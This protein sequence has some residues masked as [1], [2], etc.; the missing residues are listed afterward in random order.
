MSRDHNLLSRLEGAPPGE[1]RRL[2]TRFVLDLVVSFL[3]FDDDEELHASENFLDLGFNSLRA[4]DFKILLEERLDL[5]LSSTVL[6]DC[7]TPEALVEYLLAVR[8]GSAVNPA[9]A[10]YLPAA[11]HEEL[12]ADLEAL[13]PAELARLLRQERARVRSL[14]EAQTE[15]LAIVA[16]ACRFPGGANSPELFWQAV[17]QGRD[18]ITEVPKDHWD[19]DAFFDPDPDAPGKLYTRFGG[20]IDGID[21]FD[22]GFFG[23]SP[24]EVRELDPGQRILLELVHE[25][26]ERGG[27]APGSLAGSPTGV[28]VGQRGADYYP[29]QSSWAPEDATRY[30]ATGNSAST[31]AGRISY[32]LDLTGPCFALDT[33]CSSSL[34]ALHQAALSLRR[35]EC[36]AAIVGGINTLLD[37]FGT[38]SVCK[39]SMLA[40]DGRCKAFDER[41][42]GYVR[43]EGCG[44][45][46]LKRLSRAEADGD[47]VLAL[48]RGS[49]INQDGA[50]AGLTVPS[51]AAQESV[52]RQALANARVAPDAIDYVE[53]HGTGTSLGD[54]IEVAALD[55]VFRTP[56][57]D[58]KLR[59]GTVKTQIGHLEPA[60]GIA[61]LIRCVLSLEHETLA[62]NLHFEMPNP[63]IDWERTIVEVVDASAAWPRSERPRLAGVSSFGFSGTNAHVVLQ[64]APRPLPGC[65]PT[66]DAEL[67]VLSAKTAQ[68]L[69][70]KRDALA[71]F[72]AEARKAPDREPGQGLAV[73]EPALRLVDLARTLARGR[74]HHAYRRAFLARD[75]ADAE[76]SLRALDR[77]DHRAPRTTPTLAFLFT[78][79]GSQYAGMAREV[80]A[81]H[82]AFREAFD[83]AAAAVAACSPL[84]LATEVFGGDDATRLD[85]TDL[86][87]PALFA[88][89]YAMCELWAAFGVRPDWVLGHSIGEYAAAVVAGVMSLTDAARLVVARGRL[90][91][92]LTP[93]GAMLAVLAAP[94]VVEPLC[95]AIAPDLAIAALNC[96]ARLSVAGSVASIDALS[97]KLDA[98]GERYERLAVSRAFH[99][100]LM[101]PMLASFRERVAEVTLHTPRIPIA[102]TL[103]GTAQFGDDCELTDPDYW[104][105]HVREA[106]RFQDGMRVL[107]HADVG[108]FVEVGPAPHLSGLARRFIE[109]EGVAFI[110]SLRP[111]KHGWETFLEALGALYEAGL[112]VDWARGTRP[113]PGTRIE[114]P[115]YPLQKQRHWLAPK[116]P[117]TSAHPGARPLLGEPLE[118]AHLA[119]DEVVYV[120]RHGLRADDPVRD[121]RIGRQAL[122]PAAGFLSLAASLADAEGLVAPDGSVVVEHLKIGA[123]CVLGPD[124]LRIE[125]HLLSRAD[126][127]ATHQTLV[128]HSA[129]GALPTGEGRPWREH[130][131]AQVRLAFDDELADLDAAD[132]V[133][134]LATETITRDDLYAHLAGLGLNYGP[135]YQAVSSLRIGRQGELGVA[136]ADVCATGRSQGWID[137]ALLDGCF[138]IATYAVAE[139]L[140]STPMLPLGID[141]MVWRRALPAGARVRATVRCRSSKGRVSLMDFTLAD[142]AGDVVG[143]IEGLRLLAT[144]RA[145]LLAIGDPLGGLAF[146]RRWRPRVAKRGGEDLAARVVW[147]VG[148]TGPQLDAAAAA[149]RD[150]GA[151]VR[152]FELNV[153]GQASE[154]EGSAD[155]I[156]ALHAAIAETQAGHAAP[157][158]DLV[159]LGWIANEERAFAPTTVEAD[160]ERLLAMTPLLRGLRPR[161]WFVTRGAALDVVDPSGAAIWGLARTAAL[162]E[163]SLRW[164]TID[165]DPLRTNVADAIGEVLAGADEREVAFREG[166]RHVARLE[167]GADP[168]APVLDLPTDTPWRLAIAEYG[169]LE[170]ITAVPLAVAPPAAGEVQL[171]VAAAPL[172]FK[173]VLFTLGLLKDFT[174]IS[175]GLDQPLGLECAGRVVAVGAGVTTHAVGDAVM[176]AVP[177]AM[178]SHVNVAADLAVRAP[179][180]LTL[181]EAAGLPSVWMTVLYGL[182]RC[183]ELK[184]GDTVLVHAAAG[185]VGQAA[186]QYARSVGATVIA[187]ASR[188]KWDTLR[189]QGI[190]H[191]FDSRATDYTE[192]VLRVTGGR[193]VDVV[194]DSM[195]GDHVAASLG[196]LRE[197]GRFVE[198]GKI[199][200]WSPDEMR[201]K[202]PDARYWL[203]DL[204]DVLAADSGLQGELMR[205]LGHGFEAGTWEPL[206]TRV[207]PA[208]EAQSAFRDLAQARNIGKLVLALPTDEPQAVVRGDRSYVVTGGLGALGMHMAKWLAER[209]AGEVLLGS[210]SQPDERTRAALDA[211]E[212]SAPKTR[213]L[214][215]ALDA[216]D[217]MS[218]ELSVAALAHP[219]G[220]IVH[221]AGLLD[222][223]LFADMDWARFAKVMAPKWSGA[224]NLHA[225]AAAR[226]AELDFFV[227][228]S[229]M[230]AMLGAAGQA[231]YA[232]ANAGLDAFAAWR[233]RRGEPALSLAWGPWS[234]GGMATRVGTAE[235]LEG[236]GVGALS[237]DVAMACFARLLELPG[238]SD[239]VGLLA[240]DWPR[241]L[242]RRERT[243]LFEALDAQAG[244]RPEGAGASA[245]AAIDWA[246]VPAAARP[247]RIAGL[248]TRELARVLG[249][250][251]ASDID[252][253]APFTDLGIDSLLAVDLRNRM[254]AGFGFEL[255]VT[256][257]F[258]HAN[259]DALVAHLAAELDARHGTSENR[260]SIEAVIDAAPDALDEEEAELLAE[261]D[262]LSDEEVAALLAE[263]EDER[264]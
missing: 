255:P 137:P 201:A 141:R 241:Y 215:R 259:L 33:A 78:G 236:A 176:C 83:A 104:V 144:D 15:P 69:E 24:R 248:L 258:D 242:A 138:Q 129:E 97:A 166:V 211:L 223:G 44:V 99:S 130:A 37:P 51:S 164:T 117:L 149:V 147:L 123:A 45:V 118:G 42:N 240:I 62:P 155:V 63:H 21:Q 18:C 111:N 53:A 77:L 66:G 199:G 206:P 217:R 122:F 94:D 251:S 244:A 207:Y 156:P 17:E 139:E 249:F 158:T 222:D 26:L 136:V 127:D 43:S 190:E 8:A 105:R 9:E 106:V 185:G 5:E 194:L 23:I 257:L 143:M 231:N 3:G 239:A 183:A 81:A 146:V 170:R 235:S 151:S 89:E 54:P 79:Q 209:G 90:M 197:G 140:L 72:I 165:L 75:L 233:R 254:E 256:V 39:A 16:M 70:A 87:Q 7:A 50:S 86:T 252:T 124:G 35:G 219:L 229:S 115:T 186:I 187:T 76:A 84:D 167:A 221:A 113:L 220:G 189:R 134:A 174:G 22:A 182:G 169:S 20:F 179:A 32:Q 30:Y 48:V 38:I 68:A 102:S 73:P 10:S 157:P 65:A 114:L 133:E 250:G 216:A 58:R 260:D 202:R 14:E 181:A 98:L 245:E 36:S 227:T 162:E 95:A 128:I 60:A 226:G 246:A 1:E 88:I 109:Q 119:P 191:V 218:V 28:F 11:A 71:G 163:P 175:R 208:R 238:A 203:F 262:N 108:L 93:P 6:F 67:L 171:E 59:V 196:A 91:M 116:L 2:L 135:E 31:L 184:S 261:L 29:G 172:N 168:G 142:E 177:G 192:G 82:S 52:V 47:R 132:D 40:A 204:S 56:T 13:E 61:G 4:V 49:A 263:S 159:D 234:G 193:G 188:G 145:T 152:T 195:A 34:V 232:A 210:R 110:P 173:D 112:A 74:D 125:T 178:A 19:V 27:I 121:H 212:Q 150:A 225:V 205:E 101:E 180:R 198:L 247:A 237:P 96:D 80:Y 92:E 200:V 243:P 213:F 57:R 253:A 55:A 46:V 154:L 100:P 103:T 161:F 85:E 153:Q 64:E 25:A 126:A 120:G 264:D 148:R 107:E 224:A 12:P 214:V 230:T 160:V 131:R 228:Y 41:A